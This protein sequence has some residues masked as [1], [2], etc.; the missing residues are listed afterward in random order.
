MSEANT[1]PG[2]RIRKLPREIVDR[3]AAG[4]VV[5]RPASVVKELVENSLDATATR[6][7]VEIR[8]GGRDLILV[9]DDG[10]GMS[11][12]DLELAFASHATSKLMDVPDLDHIASFGF[13]GEALASIGAVADCRI[14][15]R[16]R[17][18]SHGH[19]IE[20]RGGQLTPVRVAAAPVGT[21]V[22]VRHLFRYVP[23][24]RKF[25]RAPSTESA[26]VTTVVQDAALANPDVGF[27]LVR[28][29]RTVFRVAPEDSTEERL[30]RFYGRDTAEALLPVRDE[31]MGIALT[32]FIARPEVSRRT[33]SAQHLYLNGRP[34]RDRSLLHAVRHGYEGLLMTGRQPVVFLFLRMDP[35]EVDV[36][37]HPAKREVRFRNQ[38]IVHRLVRHAVRDTLLAANL[39]PDASAALR[40]L[41]SQSAAP[42]T[43]QAARE[44]MEGVADALSAFVTRND[45][46]LAPT[47]PPQP[48]AAP[49][50]PSESL[51][52]RAAG[53]PQ[54]VARAARKYLQVQNT[55]LVFE[56]ESGLVV[57]DQ[58]ALHERVRLDELQNRVREGRLE[59]QRLL[60]PEILDLGAADADLLLSEAEALASLGL[61]IE[62]FGDTSVALQSVPT[63]L[64]RKSARVVLQSLLDRLRDGKGA[65][66]RVQLVDTVL[67]SIACRGA[68]MAGDPLPE[69]L[70]AELLAK[71]DLIENPHSCAHGR[72]TAVVLGFADLERRFGRQG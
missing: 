31:R 66:D 71:A 14:L 65:G 4:E 39:K 7:D 46:A 33:T 68:I 70:A 52:P 17:Q 8:S 51:V 38:E 27:T 44:R 49:G 40:L 42:P 41:G 54:L 22:E 69:Q 60:V 57:L 58:H 24:R 5:E 29:G 26:H 36:N 62:R 16:E 10:I 37:V 47:A 23:A 15:S 12:V 45:G 61:Q 67:H 64:A 34:I 43:D 9:R 11:P 28:D 18:A 50:S 13:R 1:E 55:Y 21:L 3:I 6:V 35:A 59:V 20:D 56:T 30:R 48:G 32:G 53:D 19:E 25:L 72:P 63:L 2:P